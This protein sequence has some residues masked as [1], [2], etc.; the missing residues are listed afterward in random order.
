MTLFWSQAVALRPKFK[1]SADYLFLQSNLGLYFVSLLVAN[2]IA[3]IGSIMNVRWVEGLSVRDGSFCTAQGAIKNIGNVATA[4]W[5]LV[6]IS[7]TNHRN[8]D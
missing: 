3:A 6:Y 8:R 7:Y 5:A 2:A 4:L 1:D